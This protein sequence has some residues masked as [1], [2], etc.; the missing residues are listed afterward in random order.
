MT[1]NVGEI[2]LDIKVGGDTKALDAT[3][4]K[5]KVLNTEV[6][7]LSKNLKTVDKSF[8]PKNAG[9]G[10]GMRAPKEK[11]E[12]QI[13][14]EKLAFAR[15][16]LGFTRVKA[17]EAAI[18]FTYAKRE[19]GEK[20]RVEKQKTREEREDK[21]RREAALKDTRRFFG[22]IQ[23]GFEKAKSFAIGAL[24]GGA[25]IIGAGFLA[26]K[27]ATSISNLGTQQGL[28]AEDVQRWRNVLT[29]A[30]PALSGD[31]ALNIIGGL[32]STLANQALSGEATGA[33][34][35]LGLDPS[36]RSATKVLQAIREQSNFLSPDIFTKL[37]GDLGIGPNAANALN[38]NQFGESDFLKAYSQPILSNEE[39][40]ANKKFSQAVDRFNIAVNVL[41]GK[42]LS[43]VAPYAERAID[44]LTN[45]TSEENAPKIKRSKSSALLHGIAAGGVASLIPGVGP[46]I[47]G[48]V[49]TA[50]GGYYGT[51]ELGKSPEDIAHDQE[52]VQKII[53]GKGKDVPFLEGLFGINSSVLSGDRP[54][55]RNMS[56]LPPL[57]ELSPNEIEEQRKQ[58]WSEINSN[59]DKYADIIRNTML[60]SNDNARQM[61]QSKIEV[62]NNVNV[63][64][65][66]MDS[67]MMKPLQNTF[68]QGGR[69]IGSSIMNYVNQQ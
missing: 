37:L 43:K 4:D 2:T 26:A 68:E 36:E 21:K 18:A 44:V 6:S 41:I 27:A 25:G 56:T 55:R 20:E 31:S 8:S 38:R 60:P 52:N 23:S 58:N 42:G 39:I 11:T 51:K 45:P 12:I 3:I 65:G 5:V 48:G 32:Q 67:S 15:T 69:N 61:T 1:G 63:E 17:Q 64:I 29:Q 54:G 57:R 10:S 47:A 7:S 53:S 66:T 59:P 30:N 9:T 24:T 22:T 14:R 19:R 50:V 28:K 35:Q 62:N 16:E 33:L 49:A 13:Q 46:F 40:E 34:M